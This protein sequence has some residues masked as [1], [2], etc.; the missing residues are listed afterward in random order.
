MVVLRYKE[1]PEAQREY[2]RHKAKELSVWQG[3]TPQTRQL[4]A[5]L[6]TAMIT[7]EYDL[8]LASKQATGMAP[9][10]PPT[11][12]DVA[13]WF[14]PVVYFVVCAGGLGWLV[15]GIVSLIKGTATAVSA[16]ATEYGGYFF[17]GIIG[18]VLLREL[19]KIRW[20]RGEPQS[21]THEKFEQETF[22]QKTSYEKKT[23][24]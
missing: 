8:R 15:V 12:S 2:A 24:Q 6:L 3:T 13:K 16:F 20:G 17:G 11:F 7:A 1:M 22:Y 10:Q 9:I 4:N 19:P 5:K 14:R 23:Q 21:T 18:I